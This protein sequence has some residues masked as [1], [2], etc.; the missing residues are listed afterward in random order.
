MFNLFSNHKKKED[1]KVPQ[2]LDLNHQPLKEGDI[3]ESLRYGLGKCK[4]VSRENS[5]YY[6][7]L[8]TGKEVSWVKMVDASTDLQKVKKVFLEDLN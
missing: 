3:V 4:V 8:E 6:Q 2:F 5:Y 1:K 7:S